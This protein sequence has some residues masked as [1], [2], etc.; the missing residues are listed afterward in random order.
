MTDKDW[1]R[2]LEDGFTK[3]ASS[4]LE[5]KGALDG[6]RYL[7]DGFALGKAWSSFAHLY[8]SRLPTASRRR[9]TPGV[10]SRRLPR[11]RP[12]A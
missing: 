9:A 5:M 3:R 2:A 1:S 4:G 12:T 6:S 11:L 8:K 7:V 10:C